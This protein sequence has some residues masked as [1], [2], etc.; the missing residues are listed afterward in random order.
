MTLNQMLLADAMKQK[1]YKINGSKR[2]EDVL[3]LVHSAYSRFLLPCS[4]FSLSKAQFR[5]GLHSLCKL[6]SEV[7][8]ERRIRAMPHESL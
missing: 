3:G 5:G 8:N 4:I 6:G 2:K 7:G 1:G